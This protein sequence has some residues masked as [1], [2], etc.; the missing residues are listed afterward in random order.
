MAASTGPLMA[1]IPPKADTRS[2]SRARSRAWALPLPV[3][4][5]PNAMVYATGLVP[6]TAMMRVGLALN[7]LAI[8]LITVMASWML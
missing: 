1:T 2:A 5:P 6:H 8:V 4:T 7:L 3:A